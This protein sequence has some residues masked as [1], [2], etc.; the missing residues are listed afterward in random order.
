[1]TLALWNILSDK[2]LWN[3]TRNTSILVSSVKKRCY[4]D[5]VNC[6]TIGSWIGALSLLLFSQSMLLKKTFWLLDRFTCYW[7][8]RFDWWTDSH[9]IEQDV[10]IVGQIH[11]SLNKTFWLLDRFTCHWAR[12]F[13]CWTDSHVIEQDVLTVGQIHMSLVKTFWLLDRFTC[14]CKRRFVLTGGQI[15]MLLKKTFWLLDRFTCHW[16]R[17]FDCWPYSHVIGQD[18]L[19]VGQIH[20]SLKKYVLTGGHIHMLLKKMCWRFDRF[21]CYWKRRFDC[22]TD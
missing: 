21:T 13:D 10:L 18:V 19:T 6:K 14:Y 9:V 12:R 17:R 5:A 11:M 4:S 15:H 3:R 7:T 20:M 2:C 22:W 1:M 16:T 8:R